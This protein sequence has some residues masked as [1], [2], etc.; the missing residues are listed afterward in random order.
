[1]K[2]ARIACDYI[3]GA[4]S[5]EQFLKQ[6]KGKMSPRFD[7]DRDLEHVGVANQTT[8]LSGESLAIAA[9]VRK[10]M[11]R[12]WG[13]AAVSEHFRTFDTICS[14]T[15]EREDAGPKL[16]TEPIDLMGGIGGKQFGTTTPTS[17]T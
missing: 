6:F 17:P 4:G 10:S 16:T 13:D 1:M 9:E 5:K 15:Q 3:E 12:R 14:A 8:M 11:A 7:P 2:E